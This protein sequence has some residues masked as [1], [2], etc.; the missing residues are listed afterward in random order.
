MHQLVTSK[1]KTSVVHDV[2]EVVMIEEADDVVDAEDAKSEFDQ[3]STKR[4]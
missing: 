2:A 3:S 4:S 1:T